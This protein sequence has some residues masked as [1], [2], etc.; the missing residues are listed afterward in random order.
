MLA[1][2]AEITGSRWRVEIG[3]Q[4]FSL[5]DLYILERRSAAGRMAGVGGA[6]PEG[7]PT[8]LLP[9]RSGDPVGD[10]DPAKKE[11]ATGYAFVE[12]NHV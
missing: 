8:R 11:I 1:K 3:D 4:V 9:E 5:Q 6:V 12:G 10:A 7:P 2:L